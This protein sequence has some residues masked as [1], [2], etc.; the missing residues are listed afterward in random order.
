MRLNL[1]RNSTSRRFEVTFG[2]LFSYT[3]RGSYDEISF[4]SYCFLL[5]ADNSNKVLGKC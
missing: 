3:H 4:D 1:N 5:R 2:R